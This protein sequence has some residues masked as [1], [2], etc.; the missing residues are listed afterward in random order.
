[1]KLAD[2]SLEL[3]GFGSFTGTPDK[4]ERALIASVRSR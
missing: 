2:K 4:F 1:M 3:S